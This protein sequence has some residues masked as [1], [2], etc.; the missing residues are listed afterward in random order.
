MVRNNLILILILWILQNFGLI[1]L[2]ETFNLGVFAYI[3]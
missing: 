1:G 2:I 3:Y